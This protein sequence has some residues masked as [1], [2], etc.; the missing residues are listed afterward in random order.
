MSYPDPYIVKPA[1]GHSQ[2]HTVILLHG[3][4]S[5]AK[6]FANDLFSLK[7]SDSALTLP[8]YF[9]GFRWVF[10]DAGERWCSAFNER[11][12]AW[13]D[14][15]SLED[16]SHGQD[17]QIPGLRDGIHH[18]RR[19]VESETDRM[20]GDASKIVLCGF[21]Q[22]SAV[23]LWSLLTGAATT[24]GQ[25]GGFIGLSAWMPYTREARV[26]TDLGSQV[27]SDRQSSLVENLSNTFVNIL[28]IQPIVATALIQDGIHKLP[29]YLGH[30]IDVRQTSLL[31]QAV[32]DFL[33][34]RCRKCDE[35][36]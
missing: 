10:L 28:E 14:T 26:A 33:Q 30:G 29:V 8:C 21:S 6:E 31:D 2:T 23:A 12:S 7:T 22:G 11:R 34:G 13:F 32:A 3:R 1:P 4:S 35:L 18:V 16:L 24:R 36:P 15:L 19:I 5:T 9:P 25:L 27:N 20:G 17:L